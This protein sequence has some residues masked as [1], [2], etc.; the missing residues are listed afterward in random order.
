M[1]LFQ[2]LLYTKQVLEEQSIAYPTTDQFGHNIGYKVTSRLISGVQ[3][4]F[5][6]VK[7]DQ[8]LDYGLLPS[9][10]KFI[11]YLQFIVMGIAQV[12]LPLAPPEANQTPVHQQ[13]HQK[14]YHQAPTQAQQQPAATSNK[15][16][17]LSAGPFS[18]TVNSHVATLLTQLG[19][20]FYVAKLKNALSMSNKQMYTH[21]GVPENSCL[22][23]VIKGTCSRSRCKNK[24]SDMA[25]LDT[26]KLIAALTHMAAGNVT[27]PAPAPKGA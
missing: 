11:T 14:V 8:Q 3:E 24:H 21:L 4:F 5:C 17:C 12:P 10:P 19:N 7:T 6:D 16:A 20:G 23:Y 15:R 1:S 18:H 27:A 9:T 22:V 26:N 25:C 2:I 13:A